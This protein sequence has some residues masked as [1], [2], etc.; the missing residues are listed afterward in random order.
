MTLRIFALPVAAAGII[1]VAAVLPHTDT[2]IR[3]PDSSTVTQSSFACPTRG[4]TTVAAGR[5]TSHPGAKSTAL[6][7][8]ERSAVKSLEPV[9]RWN[10]DEVNADAVVVANSDQRGAGAVGFFAG[11]GTKKDGGGLAV[12]ACPGVTQDAWYLGAGS[13]GQH[14][15]AM[16]LTNLADAPAI[17]D[18][19]MWSDEGEVDAVEAAGIVLDPFETRRIRL[20]DLAAGEPQ[21]AVHVKSRRGALS[22]AMNDTSTSVFAG[23]EPINPTGAAQKRF[24]IPGIT[25][26]ASGRQLLA[27]NP[28]DTTARVKVESLGK[29]GPFVPTG[30]EDKKVE[31]GRLAMIDLPA[32]VG[33]DATALRLTSD[34]P[35]T[36]SVRMAPT[37]KDFAFATSAAPLTGP[38]VLPLSIGDE[39]DKVRLLLTAAGAASNVR[40]TA[41]DDTMKAKGSVDVP[42]KAGSTRSYDLAKKGRFDESLDD[43][44][45]VVLTPSGSI[46]GAG[47]FTKGDG[48]S[49]VPLQDAPLTT[50]APDVRPGR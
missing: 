46:R 14:F 30:L 49:I 23:T 9:D 47:Q 5:I 1:A 25:S 20:D 35:I 2:E 39:L 15:S 16:T 29:S 45:Y 17:A 38:A 42:V 43:L 22:V 36:A 19:L 6:A 41:Y 33:G 44:A 50:F 12:S 8:P 34:Q 40:V 31:A 13:G 10:V 24:V 3:S 18:V 7:L 26:G 28:G 21:L 4:D 11:T 32:S 27:F 37:N 48:I